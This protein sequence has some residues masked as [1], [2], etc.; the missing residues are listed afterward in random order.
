VKKGIVALLVILALIVLISPG[1]VGRLAEKSVEEQMQWAADENQEIVIT[2]ERFDRSW[3][4]SEGQHRIELGDTDA[5][6]RVRAELG[7]DA[8]EATPAILID[9]RIDHGLIPVSSMSRDK[10][11]LAPGLGSAVSTISIESGDG[12]IVQLPGTIY[13]NVGLTGELTSNYKLAPGSMGDASWGNANIEA[14]VDARNRDSQFTG[15]IESILFSEDGADMQVA[16]IEFDADLSMTEYGYTVGDLKM[17]VASLAVGGDDGGRSVSMGPI[18]IDATSK[19]NGDRVDSDVAMDMVMNDMGVLGVGDVSWAL[20]MSLD[21][22]D[23]AS[24]AAV[25]DGIDNMP[26]TPD[27]S[28]AFAGI[29]DDLIDMFASGFQLHLNKFDV[30]LPQGTLMTKFN[31]DIPESDR[32]SFVWTSV[33]LGLQADADV[34]IPEA[35]FDFIKTMVPDAN[36]AVAMGILQKSNGIYVMEAAY[37]KGLLTVNGAPMPIP[38]PGLQ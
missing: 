9:T 2:S 16:D 4:S 3:F 26:D 15:S 8:G 19:L 31:F 35:L 30:A 1:I 7:F 5:A 33:L 29:E 25:T 11:S 24:M 10:G 18:N 37:K 32:D 13:S 34:R 21:G 6:G 38:L 17:S 20:D 14:I 12:E 27:P 22:V 36:V 23:A 28:Q